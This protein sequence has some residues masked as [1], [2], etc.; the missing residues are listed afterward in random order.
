MEYLD[1][2]DKHGNYTGE[3][4]LRSEV[5]RDGDY[6][7]TVH[8]WI[9]NADGD[10]LF[11]LRGP[12][13]E[14][15]PNK[16]DI[17]AA[18]HISAGDSPAESA[19]RETCE[20]LGIRLELSDLEHLGTLNQEYHSPDGRIK[21]H[22]VVE[23]YLA[24]P[25]YELRELSPEKAEVADIAFWSAETVRR[26]LSTHDTSMVPHDEEYRLVLKKLD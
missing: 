12:D 1:T 16:W 25:R 7:R 11:Q 3:K 13:K 14:T 15:H 17:S 5:H 10:L 23:V 22:E 19:V 20:E 18:G 6:H 2:T 8:V 26:K 24:R 21:D 9:R 4:K